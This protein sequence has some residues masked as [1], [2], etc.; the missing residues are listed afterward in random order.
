MVK[1]RDAGGDGIVK[2]IQAYSQ[3]IMDNHQA[4]YKAKNRSVYDFAKEGQSVDEKSSSLPTMSGG[5]NTAKLTGDQMAGMDDAAF[6]R[7]RSQYDGAGGSDTNV[8]AAAY[9]ALNSEGI[10][11]MEQ[12]RRTALE[13][14]AEGYN[15]PDTATPVAASAS[16]ANSSSASE[17]STSGS[18]S[19]W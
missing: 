19:V 15:P 11:S 4:M 9:A 13:K 1:A 17:S 10:N 2:G 8:K 3:N 12:G 5:I 14:M 16:A 6:E 18:G 7:L